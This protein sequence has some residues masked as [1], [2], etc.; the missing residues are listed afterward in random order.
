MQKRNM[1]KKS[2]QKSSFFQIK[3]NT[4]KKKFTEPA[5]NCFED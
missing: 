3:R 5:E 4:A 2:A 1:N